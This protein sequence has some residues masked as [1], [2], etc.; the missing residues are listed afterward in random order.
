MD[1]ELPTVPDCLLCAV[2]QLTEGD[3]PAA[4]LEL[5][6]ENASGVVLKIED[7]KYPTQ[8]LMGQEIKGLAVTLWTGGMDRVR[9]VSYSAVF[10]AQL[11]SAAPQVGDRLTIIRLADGRVD[12]GKFQGRQFSQWSLTVER[13][14]H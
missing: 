6:G 11:E 3:G 10:R 8:Q 14:H 9:A 13:G 12:R 5:E 4:A 7:T 2:R 1:V